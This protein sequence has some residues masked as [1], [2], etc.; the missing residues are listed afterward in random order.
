MLLQKLQTSCELEQEDI[1]IPYSVEPLSYMCVHERWLQVCI[2]GR[3]SL[4]G[5]NAGSYSQSTKSCREQVK[6]FASL[7]ILDKM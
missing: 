6:H 4:V 1:I 7:N 2:L 5:T 3:K